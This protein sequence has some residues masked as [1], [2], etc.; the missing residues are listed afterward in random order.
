MEDLAPLCLGSTLSKQWSGRVGKQK[1][2]Q[3]PVEESRGSKGQLAR[4]A[5]VDIMVLPDDL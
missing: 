2:T 5:P 1:H 4:E 3:H